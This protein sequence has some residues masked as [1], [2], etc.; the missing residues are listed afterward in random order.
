MVEEV[1]EGGAEDE[2]AAETAGSYCTV[3][4]VDKGVENGIE[5]VHY[6]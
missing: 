2:G 5:S 6:K 3:P 4:V 1:V